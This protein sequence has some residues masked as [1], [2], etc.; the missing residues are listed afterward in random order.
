MVGFSPKL[1]ES[2]DTVSCRGNSRIIQRHRISFGEVGQVK[3]Q[4][5]K[6]HNEA[7]QTSSD[8]VCRCASQATEIWTEINIIPPFSELVELA[9]NTFCAYQTNPVA[10]MRVY[11]HM[12]HVSATS[13]KPTVWWR[14]SKRWP[15]VKLLLLIAVAW[16][17]RKE[18]N[19]TEPSMNP[20]QQ[21][22]RKFI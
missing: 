20:Q 4:Q 12:Q 14:R 18:P 1:S 2:K 7:N 22:Q 19:S 3:N 9:G 5:V 17:P 11:L 13:L 15:N 10:H 21:W 16:A 6:T 8:T